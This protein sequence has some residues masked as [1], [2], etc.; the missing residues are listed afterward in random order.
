[1]PSGTLP[2][3]YPEPLPQV[4]RPYKPLVRVGTPS[5]YPEMAIRESAGRKSQPAYRMASPVSE[6]HDEMP[7]VLQEFLKLSLQQT[8]KVR[9]H[10][11]QGIWVYTHSL[12]PRVCDWSNLFKSKNTLNFFCFS[13]NILN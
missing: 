4:I 10:V 11:Q 9:G 13:V 1:M 5:A 3:Q 6:G 8:P 7:S 2:H 12:H